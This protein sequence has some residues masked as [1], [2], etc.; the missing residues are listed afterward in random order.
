MWRT[1]WRARHFYTH[2]APLLYGP[3]STSANSNLFSAAISSSIRLVASILLYKSTGY[4]Y[5]ALY[6]MWLDK[7]SRV[8]VLLWLYW[9]FSILN[10]KKKF[11]VLYCTILD[12]KSRQFPMATV[13]IDRHW[14]NGGPKY[15]PFFFPWRSFF[16]SIQIPLA[17]WP[18]IIV[19]HHFYTSNTFIFYSKI[20]PS[21]FSRVW[22][23]SQFNV[24]LYHSILYSHTVPLSLSL[25]FY[26]YLYLKKKQENI[27]I[28]L[29]QNNI[30]CIM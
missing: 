28:F 20:F 25:S 21:T 19:I 9:S 1:S 13:R 6:L 30:E 14:L 17:P 11:F 23:Q 24:F 4:L 16:I 29:T 2:R 5:I 15:W 18:P 10:I 8:L 22:S 27:P 12:E 7:M 3:P 26:I